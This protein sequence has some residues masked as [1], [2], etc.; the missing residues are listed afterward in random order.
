MISGARSTYASP[1]LTFEVRDCSVPDAMR[2]E[3]P[4]DIVFA[5][6]FLN[7]AGT[8]AELTDMFRVIEQNLAIGGKFV[9]VTTNSHD[10]WLE[11]PKMDFYGLDVLVLNEKYVTPD[12]GREAGIKAR[13]VVKGDTPFSFDV[14]QFRTDIYERCAGKAGLKLRWCDL[15]LPED[16]RARQGYWKAFVRRPT[17]DVLEAV[18]I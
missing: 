12:T 11:E 8:E 2:H 13:V 1:N 7:Y 9:G 5:G 6:W 18:R 3:A 16:E 14:F 15:V 10:P 4:F 17:F